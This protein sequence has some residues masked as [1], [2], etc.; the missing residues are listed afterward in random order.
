MNRQR[1]ITLIEL[2]G[3]ITILSIISIII[4]NVFFQGLSFTDSLQ[5][6]TQMQQEA[7]L[8]L[9]SLRKMHRS[10]DEY[11]IENSDDPN[12]SYITIKNNTS[13]IEFHNGNF[14]YKLYL[15]TNNEQ[16]QIMN[17]TPVII[18]PNKQHLQIK[19][20]ITDREN[21]NRQYEIEDHIARP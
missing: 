3:A 4:W 10:S 13:V 19:L 16:Q 12:S 14:I 2:L 15:I 21:M 20:I 11:S 5:I 1:G 9:A 6:E 8:I 7:N 18:N 17:D